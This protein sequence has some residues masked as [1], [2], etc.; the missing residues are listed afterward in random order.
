MTEIKAKVKNYILNIRDLYRNEVKEEYHKY[1]DIL[2]ALYLQRKLENKRTFSNAI[3]ALRRGNKTKAKEVIK[4]YKN[5]A[6]VAG[7]IKENKTKKPQEQEF[8]VSAILHRVIQYK[9]KDQTLHHKIYKP[10]EARNIVDK[11]NDV[12]FSLP[13]KAANIEEARRI[14]EQEARDDYSN[15]YY[16]HVS[17]ID[18]ITFTND[19]NVSSLGHTETHDMFLMAASPTQYDFLQEEVQF[20][21][22]KNECVIDNFLGVYGP[23]IKKLNRETLLRDITNFYH[24]S[25]SALDEGVEVNNKYTWAIEDGVTPLCIES[26]C[27]KYHISHYAYDICNKNF[28]KYVSKTSRNYPALV[29]YAVDNHMYLIKDQ[30]LVKS[31]VEKAKLR[32]INNIT[33]SENFHE[34]KSPF[35]DASIYENIEPKD[36]TGLIASTNIII[37][38]RLGFNAIN[39]ILIECIKLYGVPSQ[40][41]SS[42]TRIQQFSYTINKLKYILMNDPNDVNLI[43]WKRIQELC[44]KHEIQFSNQTFTKFIDQVKDK[45]ET[46]IRHIFTEDEKL[47][48]LKL[49]NNECNE[50]AVKLGGKIA[51]YIDHIRP[52]SNG[53]TNELDNIQPLC[54]SCHKDKTLSEQSDGGFTKIDD[55]VSM[56]DKNLSLIMNDVKAYAFVE[57][58][59]K[60]KN[61][62]DQLFTLDIRLCRTNILR[63]GEYAYPVFTVMDKIEVYK[64]HTGAGI[65]FIKTKNYFPMR[66]DGWYYY[67]MVDYAL[68]NNIIQPEDI[69]YV[70]KSSLSIPA[71]YYNKWIEHAEKVLDKSDFKLAINSMIGS[72]NFNHQKHE[73]WSS[74][75]ITK[76][77]PEAM[78]QF[79]KNTAH[80]IDVL[81][82]DDK[83]YFHVFKK[84]DSQKLETKSNIYNQIVQQ[85]NI[86]LH[87]LSQIIK[88]KDGRVLD[89]M[90]DAITC[91]FPD[92]ILP[93]ELKD[94]EISIIGYNYLSGIPK[95][96]LEEAHRVKVQRMKRYNLK[97]SDPKFPKQKYDIF[98]DVKDNDFTPLVKEMLDIDE[99][100]IVQGC[101]GVGKSHFTRLLQ[102]ELKARDKK[103]VSLA[104]T[105]KA[106]LIINGTTLNKFKIKVKTTKKMDSLNLDYIIVDEISMM[107]EEYYALLRTIK[108]CK[109]DLKFIL[110]GDYNQLDPVKDR[111][112]YDYSTSNILYEL[113]DGNKL[114]LTK[115]RRA[116]DELFKMLQ[117]DNIPNIK[118]DDFT[119]NP[120]K[121]NVC[122]T[123]ETRMNINQALMEKYQNKNSIKV[124]KIKADPN[125]Q[126][127]ILTEGMPLIGSKNNAKFQVINNEQYTLYKIN[128][129][130][131]QIRE[132]SAQE[133]AKKTKKAYAGKE[134]LVF[135]KMFQR[136]F[137][138]AYCITT[139]KMQGETIK[140]PYSIHEFDKMDE[141]LKYVAL[142]R[143]TTKSHINL[144]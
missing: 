131:L 109:P 136:L 79:I 108:K 4:K 38:S 107:K 116:D 11:R 68:K 78:K 9:K 52:L 114:L 3:D 119:H 88:S 127:V 139:H 103:F 55:A 84:H 125:S 70:V 141:K 77:S 34:K 22:D 15:D 143:A 60:P 2:S 137:Y 66:G 17:F 39:D 59:R 81:T 65:Y 57:T 118:Y 26:L 74:V 104:P 121:Y 89:L 72:F 69:Q 1:F 124:E 61:E 92:D 56:Y 32:D 5:K 25:S 129:D 135:P 144:I 91:T 49:H 142:T 133:E 20:L 27:K 132:K 47:N 12:Y 46:P 90:T 50:C 71:N 100:F 6:S 105:N 86:E 23:L 31:L 28:L 80:F 64:N 102:N 106:A 40:V 110:V 138:P 76:T 82:I 123:N 24:G 99:S 112:S 35:V 33:L 29:Y 134:I 96:K 14:F 43:D 51:Y 117:F 94:D 101:P 111:E 7:K 48:I 115:C 87:K 62:P 54:K 67:N 18:E 130:T 85:E 53:G 73:N 98:D 58:L 44:I 113:S 140:T 30:D 21:Q 16:S 128:G 37:Y 10:S 75:C 19:L 41:K 83:D 97:P 63:E 45:F 42:K 13:I 8:H 120:C 93:F 95:Y 36:I 126:N 122:Y